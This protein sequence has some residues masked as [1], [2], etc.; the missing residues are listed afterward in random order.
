MAALDTRYS[1]DVGRGIA[2]QSRVIDDLFVYLQRNDHGNAKDS[3]GWTGMLLLE[4]PS[5]AVQCG[6]YQQ[7]SGSGSVVVSPIQGNETRTWFETSIKP[8][9]A[10]QMQ[11]GGAFEGATCN[12]TYERVRFPVNMV[13]LSV[14]TALPVADGVLIVDIE[15]RWLC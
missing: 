3:I 5:V 12:I 13:T 7:L 15:W 11:I 4:V 6:P 2:L 9:P 1:P 10:D 8:L 14:P